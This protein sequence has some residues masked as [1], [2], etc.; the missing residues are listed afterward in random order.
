MGAVTLKAEVLFAGK[1]CPVCGEKKTAE[2]R[3]CRI[4]YKIL[5]REITRR[6]DAVI[7]AARAAKN[8]HLASQEASERPVARDII[9][10]PVLAQ[11]RIDKDAAFRRPG[12][13]IEPYWECK[14]SVP[15]GFV[16]L[17]VFGAEYAKA[18]DTITALVELKE[19]DTVRGKVSYLRAQR[20][21][22]IHGKDIRSDVK[23]A[24]GQYE[25]A[26]RY[27]YNLPVSLVAEQGRRFSVGF[28]P[29]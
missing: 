13:G 24:I 18:G 17:F 29:A 5:G 22:V 1:G 21:Q 9:W 20:A 2:A 14:K 4:C 27:I 8:G 19:K 16:S 10:G 12:N 6:V 3:T 11:R 28:I 7:Q 23:L 25:D 26:G 15:G